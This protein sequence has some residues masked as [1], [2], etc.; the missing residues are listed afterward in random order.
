MNP[1]NP[2]L[3][4]VAIL[5][6]GAVGGGAYYSG[7]TDGKKIERAEWQARE[8]KAQQEAADALLA[9]QNNVERERKQHA[10]AIASISTKYEERLQHVSKTKD[11]VIADLRSGGIRL[12][13]PGSRY[14]IGINPVP[15]KTNPPGECDGKTE[16]GLSIELA[17]FLAG[18]ATRADTIVEQL[19]S[20]QALILEALTSLGPTGP[21][22]PPPSDV[23][24][25]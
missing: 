3:W 24:I 14:S 15:G 11:R 5:V 8:L 9:A 19:T 4:L 22:S 1:L 25:P 12:R 17:E 10:L 18:E 6:L 13:D 16:R 20:C 7:R 23:L 2:Y 21:P